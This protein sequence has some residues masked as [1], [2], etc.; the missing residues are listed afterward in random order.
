MRSRD[1]LLEKLRAGDVPEILIIGGGINGVGV[2]RDLA[3]QG[4][5]ALLVEK[6]DFSSG[7]SAAPSRLIHGGLRYLE[8]GEA[9][10]VKESLIERNLLLKNASHL[11]HPLPCWV[12][13]RSW[14][15]GMFSAVLRFLGLKKTP[16]GKGALPVKL[17]LIAYDIFGRNHRTMPT[18]RMIS[19]KDARKTVP[20]IADD[21]CIIGEYYDAKIAHPERLVLE[22]VSDAERDSPDSMALPRVSAGNATDEAIELKDEI[23]GEVYTVKP[24]L[25][26]NASGVWVD[27][28][29][30]QLG[31]PSGLMG[32]TKGTHLVLKNPD[33]AKEIDDRMIYF[34]TDDHRACLIYRLDEDTLLLGT[35]DIRSDDPDDKCWTDEEIDYLFEVLKPILPGVAFSRDDIVFAYAGVRPLPR[36][37]SASAGAISRGHTLKTFPADETRPW[38]LLTLVG[39]KWT[40][41]RAFAE[42]VTDA[43]LEILGKKRL[44]GTD[45]APIGG[46]AGLPPRG[47]ERESWIDALTAKSGLP[48]ERIAALVS[49]YGKGAEKFAVAKA[50]E[51]MVEGYSESE[52]REICRNE[53]IS[54]L[55]DIILRRTLLGIG[56]A[57]TMQG[58]QEI[59]KIA[60]EELGWSDEY[61]QRELADSLTLLKTRH[62]MKIS[63]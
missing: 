32:G 44:K 4:I 40:T 45:T 27:R 34:E 47:A 3:A 15:A 7:T 8:T 36:S 17:G 51:R 52:I 39:G 23:S 43:A 61:R 25:V 33:L 49:R 2:Y 42:E 6:G 31:R 63:D 48:R 24:K 19:R 12:P 18:H 22:L 41:Y 13:V 21:I 11:V 37:D 26:I 5:A 14:T 20:A 60:G 53:R 54:R 1:E 58:L 16:G 29:Q 59:A 10:L 35:T 56:G 30:G 9:G 46:A 28:L 57:L 55:E 62:R 38:P 50:D